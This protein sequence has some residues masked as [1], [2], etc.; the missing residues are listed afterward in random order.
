MLRQK[1]Q[2]FSMRFAPFI[3]A[4][5][6]AAGVC[7]PAAAQTGDGGCIL[8]GRL[9]DTG[10]APRMP[11]V[12][13]LDGSGK[14]VAGADRQ[15]LAGTRQVRLSAPALLSRCDGDSEL[16]QGPQAPGA[17]SGVP[18][19]GPGV[20]NVQSVA[21]PRLARNGTLVELK[22]AAPTE[23]VSMVTR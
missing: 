9:G 4:V 10:W 6:A 1:L 21:F 3:C 18:A 11:G 2:E 5:M 12:E 22:L 23:R 15:A 19:I 14:V 7:L 17:K 13:L 8:A 16:A 20:L